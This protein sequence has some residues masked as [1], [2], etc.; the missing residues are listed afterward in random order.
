MS[1]HRFGKWT[2]FGSWVLLNAIIWAPIGCS[3]DQKFWAKSENTA[4]MCKDGEDNDADGIVDCKDPD[5]WSQPACPRVDSSWPG[6]DPG[7][8]GPRQLDKGNDKQLPDSPT[9]DAMAPDKAVPD[10][11]VPD[12]NLCKNVTCDDKLACTQDSCSAGKCSYT[13]KSGYC[14][15]GSAC[16]TDG[17]VNPKNKCE[18]CDSKVSPTKWTSIPG[19]IKT[20]S[21]GKITIYPITGSLVCDP[22]NVGKEDGAAAGLGASPST[23]HVNMDGEDNAACVLVDFGGIVMAKNARVVARAVSNTCGAKCSGKYCGTGHDF[24]LYRSSDG[25][26]FKLLGKP[27]ITMKFASHVHALGTS[28]RYLLV[29]RPGWGYARDHLEVDYAELSL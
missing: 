25:T 10:L 11:L 28:L 26:S 12:M 5:C 8:D 2:A 6:H 24:N 13:I 21:P 4:D 20:L 1:C 18:R 17:A 23:K 7:G 19:C 22:Q 15:V 16:F 9:P 3:P 27:A 14:L 29:C